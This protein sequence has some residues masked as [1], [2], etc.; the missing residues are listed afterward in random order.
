VERA[1][2]VLPERDMMLYIYGADSEESCAGA[3][4]LSDIGFT[5]VAETGSYADWHMFGR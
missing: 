1:D 2:D 3:Q 5:S 4:K